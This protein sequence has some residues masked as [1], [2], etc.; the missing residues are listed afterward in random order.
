MIVK[1]YSTYQGPKKEI[2]VVVNEDISFLEKARSLL[3]SQKVGTLT[4]ATI[5]QEV[6]K[7]SK[8]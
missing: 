3:E 1:K 6:C 5:S 2:S 4:T 8:F 7:L